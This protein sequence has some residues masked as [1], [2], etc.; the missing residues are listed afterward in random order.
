MEHKELF[1]QELKDAYQ[2]NKCP[3]DIEHIE[4]FYHALYVERGWGKG[5]SLIHYL[6]WAYK[7]TW[8]KRKEDIPNLEGL[9]DP[10]EITRRICG[11]G[12]RPHKEAFSYL[13]RIVFQKYPPED[14]ANAVPS[15][16]SYLKEVRDAVKHRR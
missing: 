12:R 13:K 7:T 5:Y 11:F 6:Q 8:P 15:F 3:V 4:R 9:S 1:I 2:A 16:E 10:W 14:I